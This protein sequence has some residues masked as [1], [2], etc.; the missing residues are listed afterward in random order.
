MLQFYQKSN[1]KG[2]VLFHLQNKLYM[3]AIFLNGSNNESFQAQP[4]YSVTHLHVAH[5][6]AAAS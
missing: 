6:T 1:L 3:Q 2:E 4:W 5:N